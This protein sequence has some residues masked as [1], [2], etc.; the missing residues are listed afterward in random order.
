M[1]KLIEEAA[2]KYPKKDIGR[3]VMILN[4]YASVP[5]NF[6][7]RCAMHAFAGALT[8]DGVGIDEPM[9]VDKVKI[10]YNAFSCDLEDVPLHLRDFTKYIADWRL[11]ICI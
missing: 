5:D 4:K 8:G 6:S 11:R 3:L 10:L 9:Y 1:I 2:L 7:W